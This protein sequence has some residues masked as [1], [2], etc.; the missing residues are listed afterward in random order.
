VLN[1]L[2]EERLF[3]QVTINLWALIFGMLVTLLSFVL[4]LVR[5]QDR[6]NILFAGM[7]ACWLV[8]GAHMVMY[9]NPFPYAL[10]LPLVHVAIDCWIFLFYLFLDRVLELNSRRSYQLICIWLLCALIWHV[11]MIIEVWWFGAYIMHLL[12]SLMLL[13]VICRVF[14]RAWQE[15]QGLAI[16]ISCVVL[17]QFILFITD[18]VH[19]MLWRGKDWESAFHMSQLAFPLMQIV[20]LGLLL[21]RFLDALEVAENLNRDLEARVQASRQLIERSFAEQRQRELDQAAEQEREKIYRDLHDDLGSK[22]LSIVHAGRETRLGSLASS[23]LESLRDS[24][25]R[26]NYPDQPLSGFLADLREETELRL[27]GSGH[28]VIWRQPFLL[29]DLILPASVSYNL[30]R[31]F[32]ELVSNIIRHARAD[33][34]TVDIQKKGDSWT[35]SIADNGIGFDDSAALGNGVGNIRKRAGEINAVLDWNAASGQGLTVRVSL[36]LLASRA[37]PVLEQTNG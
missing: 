25:S 11:L 24:V 4:W 5:R 18:F 27:E 29:P 30:N 33:R 36:N 8:V 21:K 35:F 16:I 34:V 31:I 15:K 20:F 12:G 10:W 3:R 7:S 23:A 19:L 32:K 26:A 37:G 9:Y 22:L 28:R 14:A 17:L 2:L 1:Q 6:V 13:H